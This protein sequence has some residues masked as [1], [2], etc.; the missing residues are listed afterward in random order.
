MFII[1]TLQHVFFFLQERN[2]EAVNTPLKPR[3]QQDLSKGICIESGKTMILNCLFE[4]IKAVIIMCTERAY[5]SV[6]I[7]DGFRCLSAG[8]ELAGFGQMRCWREGVRETWRERE[9]KR[10]KEREGES[11]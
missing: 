1:D 9:G 5:K 8:D 3:I 11:E 10:E 2:K 7:F 4:V 6:L